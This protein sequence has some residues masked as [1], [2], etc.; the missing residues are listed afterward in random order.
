VSQAN[1]ELMRRGYQA[2]IDGDV[3]TMLAVLHP[4]LEAHD[5]GAV[6]DVAT[7]HHGIEE[8]FGLIASVNDGFTD[9]RYSPEEF[10]DCGDVVFVKVQR[11]ATGAASG[12]TVDELQYHVWDIRD[13]RAVR[14][15]SFLDYA[16][17]AQAAGL[18]WRR[19]ASGYRESTVSGLQ[20]ANPE[21]SV[22][23]G[24]Q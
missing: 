23:P 6:P 2:F 17:A 13:G 21:R 15:R 18:P 14:Y 3:E 10:V 22:D 19:G 20:D 11:T 24:Y 8:F 7:T 16:P 4:Q 9:F 5:H 12:A 1:V